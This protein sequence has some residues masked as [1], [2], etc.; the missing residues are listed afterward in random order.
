MGDVTIKKAIKEARE[1]KDIDAIVLRIDSGGG[2]SLASDMIW[3][4]I[5]KTT[6]EDKKI[7]NHLLFLCQM[8][9]HL[10]AII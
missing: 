8:L 7:K 5:Y 6:T 2:S 3:R 1:N 4:E 10:V 9:L